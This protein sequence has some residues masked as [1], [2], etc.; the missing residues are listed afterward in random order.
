MVG[1]R[2]PEK[3]GDEPREEASRV[4]NDCAFQ[5]SFTTC[6]GCFSTAP[7]AQR[8]RVWLPATENAQLD[9]SNA[10]RQTEIYTAGAMSSPTS[11]SNQGGSLAGVELAPSMLSAAGPVPASGP[12]IP[13]GTAPGGTPTTA[14]S[15]YP[16]IVQ[17]CQR[18]D[19]RTDPG[20]EAPGSSAQRENALLELSKKREQ[21]ED[22]ALVLWHSFGGKTPLLFVCSSSDLY[23]CRQA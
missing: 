4:E 3:K 21:Y 1:V 6:R 23:A 11:A 14:L 8:S 7:P 5:Q 12:S 15:V 19:P 10:V 18:P 16:L 22:L 9:N 17:L 20:N 13:A 2:C